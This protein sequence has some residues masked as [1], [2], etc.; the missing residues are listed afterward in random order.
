M[1]R[2]MLFLLPLLAVTAISCSGESGARDGSVIGPQD[3]SCEDECNVDG[4]ICPPTEVEGGI[5]FHN[6]GD[7]CPPATTSTTVASLPF[8]GSSIG[9]LSVKSLLR[10]GTCRI[11]VQFIG[12]SQ[13]GQDS[14][15]DQ[16]REFGLP[17]KSCPTPELRTEEATSANPCAEQDSQA[18]DPDG[19]TSAVVKVLPDNCLSPPGTAVTAPPKDPPLLT[20]PPES[21]PV[22]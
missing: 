7:P 8:T 13:H 14:F 22:C 5:I 2:F 9:L 19:V 10:E 17:T 20:C 4:T 6:P 21:Q 18:V 12:V 3:L 16:L 15:N 11:T 1:R